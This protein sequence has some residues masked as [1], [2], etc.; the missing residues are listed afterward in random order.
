VAPRRRGELR[1]GGFRRS[2]TASTATRAP[3][4]RNFP[5]AAGGILAGVALA[6]LAVTALVATRNLG[7]NGETS[8]AGSGKT[9][10]ADQML[11][12]FLHF[13]AV[14]T[15]AAEVHTSPR[16]PRHVER[17]TAKTNRRAKPRVAHR[18][19]LVS[20][21]VQAASVPTAPATSTTAT[22]P[23]GTGASP[24]PAP[25]GAS[26]PSPLKAP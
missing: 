13:P 19:T 12:G 18:M 15:P 2:P 11:H 1:V 9:R 10:S 6:A 14:S 20:N 26:N 25:P 23:H 8:A 24:L 17:A 4:R 16:A 7:S 3:V 22:A 21:T 5:R